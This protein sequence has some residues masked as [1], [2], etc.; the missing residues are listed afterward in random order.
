MIPNFIWFAIPAGNDLLRSESITQTIDVIGSI[1]QVMMVMALCVIKN[2]QYEKPMKKPYFEGII[3]AVVL[4]YIAWCAYYL[5]MVNTA[6]IIILCIAPCLAFIIFSIIK[7]NLVALMTALAFTICH[8][9]YG[10][11]NFIL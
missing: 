8:L 9:I 5:Q 3:I 4:Y 7:K 10:L 1:F 6:T 2:K 11:V